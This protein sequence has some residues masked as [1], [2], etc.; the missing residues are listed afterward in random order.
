MPRPQ[1]PTRPAPPSLE[2]RA[3]APEAYPPAPVRPQRLAR[4]APSGLWATPDEPRPSGPKL[5]SPEAYPL[6]PDEPKMSPKAH[7]L[8]PYLAHLFLYSGSAS[9]KA[10]WTCLKVYSRRQEYTWA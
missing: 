6:G 9:F 8:D 1:R 3:A 7:F 2:A 4:Q 5:A 10:L